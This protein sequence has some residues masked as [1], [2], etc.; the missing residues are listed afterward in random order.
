[1][2]NYNI[3]SNYHDGYR[4]S[5]IIVYDRLVPDAVVAMGRRATWANPVAGNVLTG[6]EGEAV[7]IV[8]DRCL[9]SDREIVRVV[10]I[11]EETV[12][13]HRVGS[14]EPMPPEQTYRLIE[15]KQRSIPAELQ[16]YPRKAIECLLCGHVSYN[17]NDVRELYCGLCHVFHQRAEVGG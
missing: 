10:Q 16:V 4:N 17:A 1:M 14:L 2:N 9:E 7:A 3:V 8:C 13:Y 6:R 5:G 15:L 11:E 12:I